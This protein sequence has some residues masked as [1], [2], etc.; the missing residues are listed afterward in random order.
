MPTFDLRFSP[1]DGDS[2][3]LW[4]F[5]KLHP[6]YTALH[7]RLQLFSIINFLC[8][9]IFFA[10]CPCYMNIWLCSTASALPNKFCYNLFVCNF[11]I[12][13]INLHKNRNELIP[14]NMHISIETQNILEAG[15]AQSVYW[16]CYG[17]DDRG[18]GVR[19]QVGSR[20]FSFP[21]CPDRFWGSPS[22]LSNAYRGALSPR[23][24]R[25]G[26]EGDH[27]PQTSAEVN[28]ILIYTC[29]PPYA[30]MAQCLIS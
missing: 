13:S 7:T 14:K 1:E 30:F 24:K 8:E 20:I 27:S 25:P 10:H 23:A 15:I 29:T 28:K 4:N 18:V 22:L 16:L 6:D 5:D 9:G 11:R 19:V 17:L 12:E 3:F 21:H 26:S 2:A